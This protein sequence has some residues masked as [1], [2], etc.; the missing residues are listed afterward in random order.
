MSVKQRAGDENAS[1]FYR[2]T[3]KKQDYCEGGFVKRAQAVEAERLKR[4]AVIAQ[5]LHPEDYAGEMTFRQ[6]GEW[7]LKEYVP[8]K[9]DDTDNSR[10]PFMMDYFDKKLMKDITPGE[11]LTFL[12]SIEKLR[13]Y[14]ISP[15]TRNSYRALL[16][17]IYERMIRLQMYRSQNPVKFVDKIQV[18]RARTRF[19]YPAEEKL[20]TPA[21]TQSPDIYPYYEVGLGTGMRIGEVQR[22]RVEHV[23][24]NQ[25]FI[26]VPNPKNKRSRYVPLEDEKLIAL[27]R[28]RTQGKPP[29]AL[30]M[31]HWGYT[32]VL[33]HFKAICEAVGVKLHKGEAIH[34]MRH[35]FAY[36]LLSQG[37]SLYAVSLL[38]GH[39]SQDV[40][41]QHYGHLAAKDLRDVIKRAKPFISGSRI[42]RAVELTAAIK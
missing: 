36:N 29:E 14:A 6:A 39:S 15:H 38:M 11:I 3:Y 21:M 32:Y 13:G 7:W 41:Q 26:F 19:F 35:T 16:H 28:Q 27:L 12:A 34:V 30:V 18:P 4:N 2:F 17:A 33:G 9:L 40:T 22:I 8:T 10:V 5:Q 1:W 20:L 42:S 31:P 25:G 24:F 37:E 23:D